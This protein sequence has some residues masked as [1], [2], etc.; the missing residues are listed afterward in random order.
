M[1]P[2]LAPLH[3]HIHRRNPDPSSGTVAVVIFI[4]GAIVLVLMIILALLFVKKRRS[5][6]AKSRESS[7]IPRLERQQKYGK[8]EEDEEGAW[9]ADMGNGHGGIE[10][11]GRGYRG[12]G[13]APVHD[14]SMGYQSQTVQGAGVKE[15]YR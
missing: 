9:S 2:H 14:E 10:E 11:G 13:Y 4:F 12:N 5:A 8:L 6:A 3:P 15:G 7:F 1:A